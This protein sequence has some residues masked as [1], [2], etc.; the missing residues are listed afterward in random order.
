M[1]EKRIEPERLLKGRAFRRATG[2]GQR[3]LLSRKG[4]PLGAPYTAVKD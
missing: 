2:G 3:G 1:S 4:V